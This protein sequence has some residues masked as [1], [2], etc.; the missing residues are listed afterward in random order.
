M[1]RPPPPVSTFS[2]KSLAYNLV[3]RRVVISGAVLDAL[4]THTVHPPN[5]D[6]ILAY[7]PCPTPEPSCL[8]HPPLRI[9]TNKGGLPYQPTQSGAGRTWRHLRGRL[10]WTRR[11]P[12]QIVFPYPPPSPTRDPPF[13]Y[14]SV[15]W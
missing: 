15:V 3:D 14:Y 12:S 1:P 5:R 10:A 9:L 13:P 11:P 4:L 7:F 8:E 6:L 2:A